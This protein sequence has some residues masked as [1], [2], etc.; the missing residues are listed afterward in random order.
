MQPA[1]AASAVPART[2]SVSTLRK[3]GF[4]SDFGFGCV[5][6]Q[7]NPDEEEM[8]PFGIVIPVVINIPVTAK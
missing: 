6:P 3:R 5:S 4:L 7:A 1:T 2:T 8:F